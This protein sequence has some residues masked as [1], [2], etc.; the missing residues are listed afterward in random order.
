MIARRTFFVAV[1][2]V[3]TF[4]AP[5]DASARRR[6]NGAVSFVGRLIPL[7]SPLSSP[8]SDE[9]NVTVLHYDVIYA[10]PSAQ[11]PKRMDVAFACSVLAAAR[12][13]PS[14]RLRPLFAAGELHELQLSGPPGGPFAAVGIERRT[15]PIATEMAPVSGYDPERV[16]RNL[17]RKLAEMRCRSAPTEASLAVRVQ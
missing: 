1:A 17:E 4:M 12:R 7:G 14:D 9:N 13:H 15:A 16:A 3:A 6:A 11:L 8:C 10:R 5:A 2:A